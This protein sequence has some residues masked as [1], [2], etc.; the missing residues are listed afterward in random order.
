MAYMRDSTGRRLD[1][2]QVMGT[3]GVRTAFATLTAPN[4]STSVTRNRTQRTIIKLPYGVSRWRV[5]FANWNLRAT[6]A[7]GGAVS[8]TGIATGVPA[9][10]PSTSGSGR[11]LGDCTGALTVLQA[12]TIVVPTD[13]S[14]VWS[15]WFESDPIVPEIEKV[16]SWGELT[17][18]AQNLAN[19]NAYQGV[20]GGVATD[21]AS[22]TLTGKNIG[23]NA[24][25]L[26]VVM[27][28]EFDE[29]TQTGL[30]VG[31]SNTVG[32]NPTAPALIVNGGAGAL[33]HESWPAIAGSL[34]GFAAVNISV[35]SATPNDFATA[36]PALWTRVD[37][38]S[39]D[40]AF[41]VV[42]LGTNG[43]NTINDTQ[44]MGFFVQINANLRALGVDRI[45]WTTVPPRGLTTQFARLT[46][47][48]A[49]GATTV[50][51]DSSPDPGVGMLGLIG[52]SYTAE[53]RTISSITG[54]GPYTATL[55]AALTNAHAAGEPFTTQVE[56][57]RRIINNYLRQMPDGISGCVDFDKLL[58]KEVDDPS[59]DPRYFA[60][61]ALHFMRGASL[62]RAQ[63][64]VAAGVKP[65]FG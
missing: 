11:W 53:A 50:T 3:P 19:G 29:P 64:V 65:V 48:A 39:L 37:L 40:L 51:L 2:F 60:S 54:S 33:P 41:A 14:R 61:D 8:I 38:A 5:G 4:V 13:G 45:Y 23:P 16:L 36:L 21:F 12:G 26:D 7:P 46:A 25:D 44:F 43:I 62:I 58:E 28:Y 63:E 49:A 27:E 6:T 20:N 18:G 24:L 1:S 35:G 55:T 10:D 9:R 30:F 31:D 17:S 47:P 42:S 57:G 34:G 15:N 52:S 56:R 32:Y 59:G 22:A